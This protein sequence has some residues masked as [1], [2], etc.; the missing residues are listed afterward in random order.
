ME[1]L[2]SIMILLFFATL[3]IGCEISNTKKRNSIEFIQSNVMSNLFLIKNS[4]KRDSLLKKELIHFL[5]KNPLIKKSRTTV[6]FYKYTVYNNVLG[7]HNG[8]SYF[9]DNLPDPGGFSSEELSDYREDEIA[10][11]TIAKCKKCKILK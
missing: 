9:I 8:T 3:I 7:M 10:A 4:H 2:K 6:L 11:F 5:I 1:N